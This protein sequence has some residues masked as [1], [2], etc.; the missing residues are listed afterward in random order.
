MCHT[1]LLRFVGCQRCPFCCTASYAICFPLSLN[2]DL[3]W[4]SDSFIRDA[5]HP[6]PNWSGFMQHIC[7]GGHPPVASIIMLPIIDLNP[8]DETCIFSTLL[9]VQR[10]AK[11]LHIVT[12]CIHLRSATLYK[13]CGNHFFCLIGHRMQTRR[14][15]H[16]NELH[17]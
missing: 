16:A 7:K 6:Q 13:S 3:L 12:P 14:L 4:H 17:W 2:L 1:A 11:L 15:P 5:D 8:S 9:F 10:Q